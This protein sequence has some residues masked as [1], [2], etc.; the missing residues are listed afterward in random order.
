MTEKQHSYLRFISYI[1]N[2]AQG[3]DFNIDW[4]GLYQFCIKQAIVGVGFEGVRRLGESGTKPPLPILLEWAAIAEQSI[5]AVNRSL[6]K[7]CVAVLQELNAAGFDCCILKGQGNAILYP[8]P[9]SRTPGDIDVWIRNADRRQL[10]SY[11]KSKK[12]VNEI[13]FHHVEYNEGDVSV[14]LHFIP[15]SMNNPLYNHRLQKWLV[16]CADEEDIWHQR[17]LLPQSGQAVN[18]PS[19]RF[20]VVYQLAHMMHHF[21][22]EGIGLRQMMDYYYLLKSERPRREEDLAEILRHLNLYHFA[23]A[24]MYV[25]QKVFGLQDEF[26]IAPIDK[27]RGNT[28][29]NEILNGGNFGQYSGLTNHGIATKYFLKIRRNMRFVRQYPA[30]A[31]CEPVFRTWH[32]FWRIK[33]R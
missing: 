17:V 11:A 29:L 4:E 31:L 22:D 1:V 14:E 15:C 18:I 13:R 2:I 30:E 5:P 32:F 12:S 26:I 28:L 24:V 9:L 3:H 25:Q 20:N 21:F 27:Q 33:N 6:N 16:R 8:N 19:Y 10:I 23:G 7:K